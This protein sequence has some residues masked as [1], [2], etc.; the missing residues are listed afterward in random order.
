MNQDLNL[1]FVQVVTV[2][3]PSGTLI[4]EFDETYVFRRSSIH[5]DKFKDTMFVLLKTGHIR[6]MYK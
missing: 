2:E 1:Y 6:G 5:I 4:Q 3:N